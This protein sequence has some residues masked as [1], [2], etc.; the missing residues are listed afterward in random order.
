MDIRLKQQKEYGR[1]MRS[2]VLT[3]YEIVLETM[4][5]NI[6]EIGVQNGQSTK[7][8]LLALNDYLKL[9]KWDESVSK[10]L[11]PGR[12]ISVDLKDRATILD[13]E[14]SDLKK[15]WTFILGDSHDPEIINQVKESSDKLYDMAFIDGDHSYEGVKQDWDNYTPMVKPGGLVILHDITNRKEGVKELWQEIEWEK[16][17]FDWGRARGGIKPGFGIIRKPQ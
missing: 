5:K 15:Y 16:F 3:L 7:S 14:Y 17:G 9:S 4:P 1:A 2:Y 12:I 11:E 13:A 8:M 6:L 10:D